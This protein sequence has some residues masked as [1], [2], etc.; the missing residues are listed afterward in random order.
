M[1]EKSKILKGTSAEAG[2]PLFNRGYFLA[3]IT[4][5]GGYLNAYTYTVRGEVFANNQTGNMSKLGISLASGNFSEALVLIAFIFS[6]IFGATLSELMRAKVVARNPNSEWRIEALITEAL[7]IT[8][9]AF[10]PTS[11]PNFLVNCVFACI[12]A[13]Q[14]C[15][16]RS[17][18]GEAHN[19]TICTGN[20]RFVGQLFFAALSKGAWERFISYF[21]VVFTFVFGS[22]IGAFISNWMGTFATI[23]AAVVLVA[24]AYWLHTYKRKQEA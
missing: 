3:A 17:W 10:V 13:F 19:T 8:V 2:M 9:M 18:R 16:F 21:F 11:V 24:V 1:T 23:P 14:L 20:L 7:V 5:V 22:F 12:M 15:L 4:F 6:C